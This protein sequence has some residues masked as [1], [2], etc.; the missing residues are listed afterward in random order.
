MR[1]V[2]VSSCVHKTASTL[3]YVSPRFS[4][5]YH[6]SRKGEKKMGMMKKMIPIVKLKKS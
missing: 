3:S 1:K 4:E 5:T 2:S 6:L